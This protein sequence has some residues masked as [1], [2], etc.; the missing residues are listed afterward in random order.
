MKNKIII[1]LAMFVLIGCQSSSTSTGSGGNTPVNNQVIQYI[2]W[3][4]NLVPGQMRSAGF[5]DTDFALDF[6]LF[7]SYGNH[8]WGDPGTNPQDVYL[9][10]HQSDIR[11]WYIAY[12]QGII[13]KVKLNPNSTILIIANDANDR[14]GLYMWQ[15]IKNQLNQAG[16]PDNRITVGSVFMG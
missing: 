4:G 13:T 7:S 3:D 10:N 11:N 16:I 14:G 1:F 12:V 8:N 9:Y 5:S 2:V 6:A 15:N